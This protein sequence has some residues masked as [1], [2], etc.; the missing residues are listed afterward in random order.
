[1]PSDDGNWTEAVR[2]DPI[3]TVVHELVVPPVAWYEMQ[4]KQMETATDIVRMLQL[5]VQGDE[6]DALALDHCTFLFPAYLQN[7]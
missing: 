6:M 3:S 2:P 7:V 5:C 1:M 4:R